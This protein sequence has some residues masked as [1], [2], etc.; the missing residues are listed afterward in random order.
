MIYSKY[1]KKIITNRWSI[2]LFLDRIRI[3]LVR[4]NGSGSGRT[5]SG[6][7]ILIIISIY[8][9]LYFLVNDFIVRSIVIYV[10]IDCLPIL[11]CFFLS[12]PLSNLSVSHS[13][14]F[15][16]SVS[17][18]IDH[19]SF[20]SLSFSLSLPYYLFLCLPLI[21]LLFLF[22]FISLFLFNYVCIT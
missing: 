1:T 19:L 7:T 20:C 15:A 17:A 22:L 3:R 18:I 9:F 2:P 6:S 12:F 10:C 11:I 21:S 8:F 4:K 14:S 16:L 13:L 5:G